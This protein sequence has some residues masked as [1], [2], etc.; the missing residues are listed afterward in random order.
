MKA[1]SLPEGWLCIVCSNGKLPGGRQLP[2]TFLLAEKDVY[3]PD[4]VSTIVVRY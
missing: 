3:T 2:E 1:E 4:L